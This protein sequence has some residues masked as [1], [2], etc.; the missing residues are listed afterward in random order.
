M[1][2]SKWGNSLAI[3]LPA[4]VVKL[5]DLKEGDEIAVKVKTLREI[6]IERKP[7]K[8]ELLQR[9]RKFRGSLPADFRF[10]RE[11]ANQR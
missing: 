1:Q 8:K 9:L 11:E 6:E 3:R 2:V 7:G 5:L 4:P 10:D